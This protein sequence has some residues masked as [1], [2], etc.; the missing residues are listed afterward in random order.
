M[1]LEKCEICNTQFWCVK[2]CAVSINF[3]SNTTSQIFY[4]MFRFQ[5]PMQLL[6][7]L[8]ME[9][10]KLKRLRKGK[11]LMAS[12]LL[13][14]TI[15]YCQVVFIQC[16][17]RYCSFFIIFFLFFSVYFLCNFFDFD[18]CMTRTLADWVI[19]GRHFIARPSFQNLQ[20]IC[21]L[22]LFFET[23]LLSRHCLTISSFYTM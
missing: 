13:D 23:R 15:R 12:T 19:F 18:S 22:N 11:C 3:I 6:Y 14:L 20:F 17:T 10:I 5:K 21:I 16:S 1:A 9:V 7:Q 8:C 2:S 4:V